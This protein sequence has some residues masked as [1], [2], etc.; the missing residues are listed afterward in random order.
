MEETPREDV[1]LYF[2]KPHRRELEGVSY[3]PGFFYHVPAAL[4]EELVALGIARTEE[5]LEADKLI[6]NAA[7]NA[8]LAKSET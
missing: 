5:Q 4:A 1:R 3:A 2:D 8:S 6:A 7:A